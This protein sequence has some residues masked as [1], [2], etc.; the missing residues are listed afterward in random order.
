M[1]NNIESNLTVD[2]G[3]FSAYGI[4]R[5]L[6]EYSG[7]K[8]QFADGL[9]ASANYADNA[10]ASA[11]AAANSKKDAEA[12]A[13]GKRD[14]T[15]VVSGDP[16]YHNNASYYA[17]AAHTS[18]TNA[19]QSATAAAASASAAAESARTLVIDQTLTQAGQA[20]EAKAAGIRFLLLCDEIPDTAQ[21]IT[22]D[23]S[24]GAVTGVAHKRSGTTVRTDT[25]V[26]SESSITE[27]RTLATGEALAM[28]TDL[29]TLA[30]T[31]TYTAAA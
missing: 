12:Y 7:T 9:T 16:A 3:P 10:Q 11:T 8:Q 1:A 24:T 28:V 23:A 27:T 17:A 30:T 31:I 22:K 5:D 4:A 19:G 20:A 14:G 13:V 29:T 6:G 21:E 25:F 26:F 18:E 2:L 15:D